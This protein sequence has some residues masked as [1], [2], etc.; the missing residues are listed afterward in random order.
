MLELLLDLRFAAHRFY[1]DLIYSQVVDNCLFLIRLIHLV[2][3]VL[4]F[5]IVIQLRSVFLSAPTVI[6]SLQPRLDLNLTVAPKLCCFKHS[7]L[8]QIGYF[9]ANC[10]LIHI[11]SPTDT[12]ME[13]FGTP[14][15]TFWNLAF[16]SITGQIE[17]HAQHRHCI[18]WVMYYGVEQISH[19]L[20]YV[21]IEI[22]SVNFYVNNYA[23]V[24]L[25]DRNLLP[26]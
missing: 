10:S 26:Q 12:S 9:L 5:H 25:K 13:L 11:S 8:Y 24:Q 6:P 15:D 14:P 23:W 2:Q 21:N 19:T 4:S 1:V 7:L 3:F 18:K 22:R 17:W 16:T 20:V